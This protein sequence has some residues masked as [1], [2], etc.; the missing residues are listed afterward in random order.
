MLCG[1]RN[2]R[3]FEGEWLHVF[4]WLSPFSVHL[5]LA[6]Y[7]LLAIARYKIKNSKR[8]VD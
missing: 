6:Q 8:I 7:C 3:E 4:V 1:S 5:Q 2:G